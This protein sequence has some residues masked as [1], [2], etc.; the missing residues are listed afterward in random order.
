MHMIN[1]L[2]GIVT[3]DQE[4]I[5]LDNK[6]SALQKLILHN[7]TPGEVY[8]VG[9]YTEGSTE[10][11][12]N[13]DI[14]VA[15]GVE[16]GMGPDKYR[17]IADRRVMVV[18]AVLPEIP[19]VSNIALNQRYIARNT[20]DGKLYYLW[21]MWDSETE[22]TIRE[23]KEVVDK[24]TIIDASTNNIYVCNP[25]ELINFYDAIVRPSISKIT[26]ENN[27]VSLEITE[28]NGNVHKNL[29]FITPEEKLFLKSKMFE[30]NFKVEINLQK[31]DKNGNPIDSVDPC[32]VYKTIFT[33]EPKYSEEKVE[34]N[35]IPDGWTFDEENKIYT[36][37]IIGNTTVSSGSPIC[38]YTKNGYTGSKIATQVIS[39]VYKYIII[40]YSIE[41][42]PTLEEISKSN[43]V[44]LVSSPTGNYT[45][46][47]GDGLYTWF[48]FPVDMKPTGITQLGLNYVLETTYDINDIP[49]RGV[50]LGTYTFYRSLNTGNGLEQNITIQ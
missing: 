48:G 10:S 24:C 6:E 29:Y 21:R 43:N 39:E 7:F 37:E 14:I 40:H 45:I 44:N 19:D 15:I 50:N 28:S 9:Y 1:I 31:Y 34:L 49:M 41:E 30:A 25:P 5:Y 47:P 35:E 36:K 38:T 22:T 12:I 17:I 20:E 18:T 16:N 46:Q 42:T 27:D 33:L 4:I 32:E 13:T 2:N 26:I 3:G 8:V 23:Q 11:D